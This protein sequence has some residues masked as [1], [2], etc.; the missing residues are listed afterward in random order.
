MAAAKALVALSQT[1]RSP[2]VKLSYPRTQP[3]GGVTGRDMQNGQQL[4]HPSKFA[5]RTIPKY[6]AP[7]S[8]TRP[9]LHQRNSGDAVTLIAGPH[10]TQRG[11][12]CDQVRMKVSGNVRDMPHQP[13]SDVREARGRK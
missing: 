7:E 2:R 4:L 11:G 12:R 3:Q 9:E 5:A 13:C 6:A 10:G 8:V 1:R